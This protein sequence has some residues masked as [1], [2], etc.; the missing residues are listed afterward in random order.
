MPVFV[1]SKAVSS[2]DPI[3][4][5]LFEMASIKIGH[6]VKLLNYYI[7]KLHTKR[8][9]AIRLQPPNNLTIYNLSYYTLFSPL[10]AGRQFGC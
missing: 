2:S 4:T 7:V 1:F 6:K 5:Y 9:Y 3:S 8:A 10:K